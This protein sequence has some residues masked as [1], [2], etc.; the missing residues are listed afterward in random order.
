MT[1]WSYLVFGCF[2]ENVS[3]AATS[4][5]RRRL[6]APLEFVRALVIFPTVPLVEVDFCVARLEH[7]SV[8]HHR[9]HSSREAHRQ[10]RCFLDADNTSPDFTLAKI[11]RSSSPHLTYPGNSSLLSSQEHGGQPGLGRSY[12]CEFSQSRL[13][14]QCPN[15]EFGHYRL[16]K[17]SRPMEIFRT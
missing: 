1:C 2:Y 11:R 5:A 6:P 17:L 14:R 13:D 4:A 3:S 16:D 8:L 10:Q 12:N 7:A 15:S 9:A